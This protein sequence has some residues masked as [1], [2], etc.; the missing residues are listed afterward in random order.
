MS[1]PGLEFIC[2]CPSKVITVPDSLREV[3][4]HLNVLVVTLLRVIFDSVNNGWFLSKKFIAMEK[5]STLQVIEVSLRLFKHEG[6]ACLIISKSY[7]AV[8]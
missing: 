3:P 8:P 6:T 1:Y 4:K 7:V 5:K 2:L